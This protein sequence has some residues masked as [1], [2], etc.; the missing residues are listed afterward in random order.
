MSM[1]SPE[2]VGLVAKPGQGL[3]REGA[4]ERAAAEWEESPGLR[5]A[6]AQ[7]DHLPAPEW[8]ARAAAPAAAQVAAVAAPPE[9]AVVAVAE[10]VA[11]VGVPVEEEAGPGEGVDA[12]CPTRKTP[13]TL[14]TKATS[15][16]ACPGRWKSLPG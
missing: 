14:H 5:A 9:R 1:V 4:E 10:L 15:W 12:L 11:P 2:P 13:P 6:T 7:A 3:R 16:R 8:E